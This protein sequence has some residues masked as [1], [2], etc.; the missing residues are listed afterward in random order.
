MRRREFIAG[1]GGAAAWPFGVRAADRMPRLAIVT[2]TVPAAEITEVG[3][4]PPY[5]AL[6]GELRKLGYAEGRNLIVEGYSAEGRPER[7]RD[8]AQE[9]AGSKPDVILVLSNQLAASVQ[10]ATNAIPIV[11]AV[12]DPVPFGNVTSIPRPGANFT[13]I[14]VNVG[15]EIWGKRLQMLQEAIP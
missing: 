14:S 4:L 8:L 2:P 3:D 6:F 12:A 7:Y 13:A 11:G 10:T 9:V 15:L 1:L 5:R